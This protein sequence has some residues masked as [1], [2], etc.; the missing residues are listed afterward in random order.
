MFSGIFI[1]PSSGSLLN[2]LSDTYGEKVVETMDKMLLVSEV[3]TLSRH[4]PRLTNDNMDVSIDT[5][6]TPALPDRASV[7]TSEYYKSLNHSQRQ[8]IMQQ[9]EDW[10]EPMRSRKSAVSTPS[11]RIYCR[12]LSCR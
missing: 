12:I 11:S 7:G 5:S 1:S 6:A 10:E 2:I 4:K 9:L 3:A 8:L